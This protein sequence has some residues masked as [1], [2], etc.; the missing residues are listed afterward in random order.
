VQA[1]CEDKGDDEKDSFYEEL[2]RVFDHFH[3]Y[4]MKILLGN[5][6][7]KIGRENIFKPTIGNE[8]LHEISNDN[9][10]RVVNFATSKNLVVKSIMFPHRKVHKYTWASPEGNTHNQIDQVL[11][12]YGIQVYLMSDLSEGLTVILTT[13]WL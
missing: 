11:I 5:F 3:R 10:V 7:E 8:S 9:G 13:I 1:Q 12:E 6:N 4:N 2:G